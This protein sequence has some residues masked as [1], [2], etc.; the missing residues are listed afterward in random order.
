MRG[1]V[2]KNARANLDRKQTRKTARQERCSDVGGRPALKQRGKNKDSFNDDRV[3]GGKT[4][5]KTGR[6]IGVGE[7]S[8]LKNER[9]DEERSKEKGEGES[10]VGKKT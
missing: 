6:P 7:K 9:T 2:K 10:R 4:V 3:R 8:R 5:E 1:R